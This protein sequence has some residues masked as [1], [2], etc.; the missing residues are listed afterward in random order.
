MLQNNA[1]RGLPN[2]P[3][4]QSVAAKVAGDKVAFYHCGFFS[5]HNT[6]F[7]HKGRHFYESC[8]I[9]GN[10][11]FIFGRGQ[12]LFQASPTKSELP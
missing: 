8:Y 2:L 3:R 10:L 6:L 1:E 7:D 9:Q 4:N 11:D 5:P 12:S